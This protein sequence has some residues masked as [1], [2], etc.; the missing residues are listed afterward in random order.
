MLEKAPNGRPSDIPV[1]IVADDGNMPLSAR[2]G[3][4]FVQLVRGHAACLLEAIEGKVDEERLVERQRVTAERLAELQAG[5]KDLIELHRRAIAE[6]WK[7]RAPAPIGL[8]EEGRLRLLQLMGFLA[9]AY[10]RRALGQP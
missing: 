6:A 9:S 8:L 10:R 4:A 5:P 7:H 3:P 1:V 2:A